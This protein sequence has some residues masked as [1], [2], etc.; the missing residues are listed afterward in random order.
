M[1]TLFEVRQQLRT[2]NRRWLETV[3]SNTSER[4]ARGT[5]DS[6]VKENPQDYFELVKVERNEECLA[7]TKIEN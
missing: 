7:F 1:I 5:Y 4:V 6:F 3:Y 2:V